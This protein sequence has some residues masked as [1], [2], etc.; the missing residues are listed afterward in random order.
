MARTDK[1]PK[2]K[3]GQ[4]IMFICK[5]NR[6]MSGKLTKKKNRWMIESKERF[7]YL[8]KVEIL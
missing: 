6:K 7:Y 5:M 1:K 2:Y 3:E 8:D 4:K